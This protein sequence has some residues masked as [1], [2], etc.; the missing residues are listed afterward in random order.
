M[1]SIY[2]TFAATACMAL[3]SH[4]YAGPA[5]L[6]SPSNGNITTYSSS[7]P[8]FEWRKVDGVS[9]YNV[10]VSL[11]EDFPEQR[12]QNR[13][14]TG[15]SVCWNNGQGWEAKG[16]S[17]I[18]VPEKL[19]EGVT[20]Y[21]RIVSEGGPA[22]AFSETRNF[23]LNK[24]AKETSLV[25]PGH[26]ATVSTKAG[27][28]CFTWDGVDTDIYN[29][30]ISESGDFPEQRW[31]VNNLTGTSV[32]WNNGQGWEAKG[33]SPIPVPNTLSDDKTYYWRVVTRHD[34]KIAFSKTNTFTT[35]KR[36]TARNFS[37]EEIIS[38]SSTWYECNG[39]RYTHIADMSEGDQIT[40]FKVF[41]RSGINKP[42]LVTWNLY[43]GQN[44]TA[45]YYRRE[46]SP[47]AH[48][49]IY[50]VSYDES[51]SSEM[52][53]IFRIHE[54][55]YFWKSLSPESG[56]TTIFQSKGDSFLGSGYSI[57]RRIPSNYSVDDF[58]VLK[59]TDQF[60]ALLYWK[61]TEKNTG[62]S[63]Y[64]T[65]EG[66]F[67]SSS[68]S[69]TQENG[70]VSFFD[71]V[72]TLNSNN[73]TWYWRFDQNDGSSAYYF[74]ENLGNNVTI[75]QRIEK[76]D[77]NVLDN[78]K[79]TTPDSTPGLFPNDLLTWRFFNAA[80]NKWGCYYRDKYYQKRITEY[81]EGC[82]LP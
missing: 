11:S 31:Q 63:R 74:R 53:I 17:P 76:G 58:T 75:T 51:R 49:H 24:E 70:K 68:R 4:A 23:V 57:S 10:T 79:I 19:T 21:W 8:C 77:G 56:E 47:N 71:V 44:R 3:S 60:G 12:W 13:F 80:R 45:T 18:D 65:S 32:C 2:T 48:T 72:F 25:Y 78:F 33:K 29:I 20:Y 36:L 5:T 59:R 61:E 37:C 73:E 38:D 67:P 41:D 81:T 52:T 28:P 1:R 82:E 55:R 42:A 30:T 22:L 26:K 43:D 39:H 7:A 62:D 50:P 14:N 15:S 27:Q 35:K 34:N 9:S 54:E 66:T 6:L 16:K 64:Y 46:E 40:E 69:V